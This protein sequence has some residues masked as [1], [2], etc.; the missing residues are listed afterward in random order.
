MYENNPRMIPKQFIP[1]CHKIHIIRLP[2]TPNV[3][4]KKKKA[5][6][7]KKN[8]ASST[9]QKENSEFYTIF[10][11]SIIVF[12]IFLKEIYTYFSFTL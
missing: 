10:Q 3:K 2:K 1:E 6:V 9:K 12:D 7:N 5:V 4:G 11:N 8:E